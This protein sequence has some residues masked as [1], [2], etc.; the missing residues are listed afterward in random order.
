[1]TSVSVLFKRGTESGTEQN[2]LIYQIIYL[3]TLILKNDYMFS[4]MIK[5]EWIYS[6]NVRFRFPF[7]NLTNNKKT[8]KK[9]FFFKNPSIS[10][11]VFAET[12][13]YFSL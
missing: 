11:I 8:N 5:Y 7:L 10:S 13:R 3:S 6:G 4:D 2:I 9:T 12:T 1:M